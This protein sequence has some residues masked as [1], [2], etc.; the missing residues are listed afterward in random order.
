MLSKLLF[1]ITFLASTLFAN[2]VLA[3]DS[4]ICS[5]YYRGI[6]APEDN[7]NISCGHHSEVLGLQIIESQLIA[8]EGVEGAA[9]YFIANDGKKYVLRK[10]QLAP[11]YSLW[12]A[13]LGKIPFFLS[14]F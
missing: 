8:K 7:A 14:L 12:R 3:V 1:L 13:S 10:R 11:I 2:Q 5:D 4:S 9:V 6:L